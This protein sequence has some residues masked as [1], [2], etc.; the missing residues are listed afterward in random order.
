MQST[1][2]ILRYY[3][4][5]LMACASL[6]LSFWHAELILTLQR[7]HTLDDSRKD[8]VQVTFG[9]AFYLIAIGALC[10]IAALVIAQHT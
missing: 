9:S 7:E 1:L 10:H 6:A 4:A 5:A 8:L 3:C 2:Y